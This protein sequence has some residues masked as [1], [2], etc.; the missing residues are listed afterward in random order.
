ML[1]AFAVKVI[2]Y[3]F[4]CCVSYKLC[5]VRQ[6]FFYRALSSL[7]LLVRRPPYLHEAAPFRPSAGPQLLIILTPLPKSIR[8]PTTH[9]IRQTKTQRRAPHQPS[10]TKLAAE[11]LLSPSSKDKV[12]GAPSRSKA[13][14]VGLEAIDVE[15]RAEEEDG[16]EEHG[17]CL[18]GTGML[19]DDEGCEEGGGEGVLWRSWISLLM[20]MMSE[21][22][23]GSSIYLPRLWRIAER[24]AWPLL[25]VSSLALAL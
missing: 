15:V 11:A 22:G 9:H 16:R 19:G 23:V 20:A 8:Q 5:V 12:R 21:V 10:S 14:A 4:T 24:L 25:R 18:P 13:S 7:T 6:D 1:T 2:M 17:H 3:M